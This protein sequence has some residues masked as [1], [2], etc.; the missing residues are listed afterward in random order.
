MYVITLQP[1]R[2]V[3]CKFIIIV[4]VRGCMRACMWVC[5][6]ACEYLGLAF[7]VFSVDRQT[8]A[9]C[10]DKEV[11]FV[12]IASRQH[13]VRHRRVKIDKKPSPHFIIP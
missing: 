9:C 11:N 8:Y 6:C 2:N 3:M 7:T 12:L 10:R 4:V 5:A 13:C 1:Y